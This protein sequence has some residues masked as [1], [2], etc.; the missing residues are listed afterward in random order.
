MFALLQVGPLIEKL[1]GTAGF[2]AAYL[3]SGVAASMLSL[4]WNPLGV[5]VGASGAIFGVYGAINQGID[6][7]ARDVLRPWSA[8]RDA[9]AK[10]VGQLSPGK[11]Q[12]TGQNVVEYLTARQEAWKTTVQGLRTH[13]NALLR[14]GLIKQAHAMQVAKE[15]NNP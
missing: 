7:A 5:S 3:L 1:V 9:L 15:L 4:A 10:I 13:N 11:P 8:E 14:Q 6:V 12:R 2:L